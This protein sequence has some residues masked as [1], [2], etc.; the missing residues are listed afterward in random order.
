[1]PLVLKAGKL[2]FKDGKLAF[3]STP[4]VACSC[5]CDPTPCGEITLRYVDENR[6][7]DD[8]FDIYVYNPDT[9]VRRLIGE[10]DMTSTPPG[11]CGFDE[12]GNPCPQTTIELTFTPEPGDIG[13]D[14]AFGIQAEFKRANCCGTGAKFTL[15]GPHG[16]HVESQYFG[17]GGTKQTFK[18][19]DVC[20]VACDPSGCLPNSALFRY[21]YYVTAE[22]PALDGTWDAPPSLWVPWPPG[23]Q[24][25]DVGASASYL[26]PDC[27]LRFALIRQLGGN[28]GME[29]APTPVTPGAPGL[30]VRSPDG[31]YWPVFTHDPIPTD[32]PGPGLHRVQ[33]FHPKNGT[34]RDPNAPPAFAE[35]VVTFAAVEYVFPLSEVCP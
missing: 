32:Q 20:K 18:M 13:A 24:G 29:F 8:V 10:L 33:T 14:C 17:S 22:Q 30:W 4:A 12:D 23:Y 3:A 26:W 9:D 31:K 27:T 5:C 16:N 6:C 25:Q 7:E 15:I 21:D 1:M 35:D 2:L 19:S 34:Y 28:P 11:C